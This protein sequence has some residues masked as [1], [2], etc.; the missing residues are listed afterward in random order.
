VSVT[1]LFLTVVMGIVAWWLWQQGLSSK[2]WL[3]EGAGGEVHEANSHV[4]PAKIGLGVFLA[5]AAALFAL[6]LSAYLMRSP[7]GDW[8]AVPAPKVLWLNTGLLILS[9]VALHWA[10]VSARQRRLTGVKGGL[11]AGGITSVAF[12]VG[13]LWAWQLLIADGYFL[14]SN[15]ANAFFYLMTA[16]HGLHVL[17]GLVALERTAARVWG[18]DRIEWPALTLSVELC[19]MY[20]HFL[21]LVWLVLFALLMGWGGDF[22]A[23]CRQVLS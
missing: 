1:L 4:P 9:S 12:L 6:L 2:P 20:W 5:V 21:L 13:Q 7:M 18:D 11:A 23:I 15:P 8:L 22:I 14:Q 3:E 10:Q 17:G 19:A 16:L